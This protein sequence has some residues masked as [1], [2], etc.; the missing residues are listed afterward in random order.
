MPRWGDR[1]PSWLT[2]LT[3]FLDWPRFSV[4]EAAAGCLIDCLKDWLEGLTDWH[5][6]A[7]LNWWMDVWI[8]TAVDKSHS[9]KKKNLLTCSLC[10]AICWDVIPPLP[11][12]SYTANQE[13]LILKTISWLCWFSCFI[14]FLD[15]V[16]FPSYLETLL[17][18][19]G[20]HQKSISVELFV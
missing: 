7:Y 13:C 20:H 2:G 12:G 6:T 5:L 18:S 15:K 16:Q 9:L 17:Y 19:T 4:T 10:Y 11:G 8:N 3:E 14:S 1:P